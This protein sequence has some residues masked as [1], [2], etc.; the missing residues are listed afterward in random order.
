MNARNKKSHGRLRREKNAAQTHLTTPLLFNMLPGSIFP[1]GNGTGTRTPSARSANAF[2]Q[3][4]DRDQKGGSRPPRCPGPP[5]LPEPQA[6]HMSPASAAMELSRP[7]YRGS[8]M[9]AS[10]SCRA[11]SG[12]MGKWQ[13]LSP[14]VAAGA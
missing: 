6:R 2:C 7:S 9:S 5:A 8:G 13:Q 4:R 11:Q 3:D 14:L 10:C 12:R 1:Q